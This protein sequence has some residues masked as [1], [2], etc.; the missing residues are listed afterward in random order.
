MIKSFKKISFGLMLVVTLFLTGCTKVENLKIGVSKYAA[1]GTKAFAVTT[2]VMDGNKIGKILIDEYQFLNEANVTCVPNGNS[3]DGAVGTFGVKSGDIINCLA[4][5]RD[6]QDFYSTNM[7]NNGGATQDLVVSY[8]AI[9]KYAVG[10]TVDELVNFINGK[11]TEEVM[12]AVSGSTLVDTKG[13][14][15]AIIEAA[16][17]AK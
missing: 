12:D 9:E 10:K 13:Y 11:D 16:K 14:I 2:V 8:E 3:K 7:S 17:N 6:N 1:H 15:E 5:K 4:S